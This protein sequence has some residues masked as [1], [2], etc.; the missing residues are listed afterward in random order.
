MRE[1]MELGDLEQRKFNIVNIVRGSA[2]RELP[3]ALVWQKIFF[4]LCTLY[5][6]HTMLFNHYSITNV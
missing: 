2:Q 4:F 6:N 3:V 5:F 1:T